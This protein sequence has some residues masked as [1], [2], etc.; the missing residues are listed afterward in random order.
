MSDH[1]LPITDDS[2]QAGV[3]YVVA[4]PIGHLDDLTVRAAK[5]LRG[6]TAVVA[7]DTRVT[8]VL[9][10]HI[11]A[12]PSRLVSAHNHNEESTAAK[13]LSMLAAGDSVA[14][15]SDAG[16]PG[17][18]D[19]GAIIVAAARESR[20]LVIVIPG[21][22]A[23]VS[24]ISISGDSDGRFWFEGFL[25]HSR[26]GRIK[27][28]KQLQTGL[29]RFVLYESPH[30]IS[31]CLADVLSVFGPAAQVRL[32]RELT[33][34]FEESFVGTVETAIAWVHENPSRAKGE[35]V[36]S[37]FEVAQ[38]QS[39]ENREVIALLTRL[40]PEVGTNTA[41][42]IAASYFNLSKDSVYRLALTC[43]GQQG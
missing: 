2:V 7:E 14:I 32:G 26:S 6:V 24:L 27:R 11:G 9:L 20:H 43:K 10:R 41:T 42:K 31:D 5:V 4:T 39:T 35:Y 40:L 25:P 28:L 38:E 33:K 1:N 22:S 30:R 37:I 8:Q 19:P 23:V 15:V 34:R 3:L 17:I 13:V 18:S 29:G 16:T 36:L 21:A 12:N